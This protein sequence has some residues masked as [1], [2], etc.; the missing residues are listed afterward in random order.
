MNKKISLIT[1][2]K[3]IALL[4]NQNKKHM[5]SLQVVEKRTNHGTIME[6]IILFGYA[7]QRTFYKNK[8]FVYYY[9]RRVTF[10]SNKKI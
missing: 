8:L 9:E 6:R 7:S 5:I 1:Y 10:K 3:E 2:V 4:K